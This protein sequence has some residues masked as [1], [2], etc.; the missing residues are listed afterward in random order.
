MTDTKDNNT[1]NED[2][3]DKNSGGIGCGLII[4][5]IFILSLFMDG[6]PTLCECLEDGYETPELTKK[7]KS[8]YVENYGYSD[9]SMDEIVVE[10][11]S[12][13]D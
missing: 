4:L 1:E 6:E 11:L 13:C 9:L 3:D 7:C 5:V 8:V 10:R 2:T 12:V